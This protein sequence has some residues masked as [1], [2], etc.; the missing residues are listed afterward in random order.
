MFWT[1]KI[2]FGQVHYGHLL[3]PGQVENFTIYTPMLGLFEE[4]TKK[5]GSHNTIGVKIIAKLERTSTITPQSNDPCANPEGGTGGPDPP[6][7]LKITK[8]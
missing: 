4:E 6:P 8:M 7:P 1:S 5:P 2:F 3:V